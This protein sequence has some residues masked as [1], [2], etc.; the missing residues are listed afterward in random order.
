MSVAERRRKRAVERKASKVKDER[1]ELKRI[2]ALRGYE[3]LYK[4][5]AE[6]ATLEQV[7]RTSAGIS[8][9]CQYAIN[10]AR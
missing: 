6:S 7:V 8:G 10:H 1:E 2:E 3:A 4:L 5:P 9:Y